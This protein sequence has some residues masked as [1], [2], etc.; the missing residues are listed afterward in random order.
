MSIQNHA[1][2]DHS[3][4]W[5]PAIGL[6]LVALLA[7]GLLYSLAGAGLGR[8][9][10]P[11]QATGSLV[12]RDGKAAGS[13]LVAQP[14]VADGYFQARPSAADY[15]PMAAAGSNLARSNPELR[16]R[17]VDT[18]AAVAAREGIAPEAVPIEL[19]TQSGSG[20]DPHITPAGARMQV[21]RVAHARGLD[22]AR[23]ERLVEQHTEGPQFGLLG[24]PRVDVLALNLA[25]D[26]AQGAP[27][28]GA[29]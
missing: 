2:I 1:L 23:V 17:I 9:L 15:D 24:Q 16:R 22:V 14:F 19:V 13:F 21:A 6:A 4:G 25:L 11:W 8:M 26:A 3:G 10:F 7:M 27:P 5:R 29:Q 20:L 28:G 12:E 18:R